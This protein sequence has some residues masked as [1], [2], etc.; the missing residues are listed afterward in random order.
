MIISDSINS[1]YFQL[2]L[3]KEFKF[4]V[5]AQGLDYTSESSFTKCVSESSAGEKYNFC[6]SFA[7]SRTKTNLVHRFMKVALQIEP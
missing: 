4:S 6:S 5:T 2:E 7:R 3:Y 1:N